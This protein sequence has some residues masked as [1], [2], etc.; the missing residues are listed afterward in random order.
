MVVWPVRRARGRNGRGLYFTAV[1][2][3]KV[4]PHVCVTHP[5]DGVGGSVRGRLPGCQLGWFSTASKVGVVECMVW[6]STWLGTATKVG[7]Y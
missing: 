5:N 7:S 3:Q 6:C 2:A 4:R 1:A